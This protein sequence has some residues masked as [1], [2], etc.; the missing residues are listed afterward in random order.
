M[1]VHQK[2]CSMYCYL[3]KIKVAQ[4]GGMAKKKKSFLLFFSDKVICLERK[5]V[6]CMVYSMHVLHIF[7]F[8]LCSKITLYETSS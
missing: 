7:T 2:I 6:G 1:F 8:I 3:C 5:K 4:V